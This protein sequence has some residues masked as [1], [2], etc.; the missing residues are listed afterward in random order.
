MI[1]A[2]FDESLVRTAVIED[3]F[4]TSVIQYRR[5]R[6]LGISSL[7]IPIAVDTQNGV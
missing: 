6:G 1:S 7:L 3:K 4:S 2:P 5:I